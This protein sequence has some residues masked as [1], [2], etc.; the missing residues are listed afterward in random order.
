LTEIHV[1]PQEESQNPVQE[2]AQIKNEREHKSQYHNI[3]NKN[4]KSKEY[5]LSQCT[6]VKHKVIK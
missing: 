1:E 4:K 5:L 3:N 2:S 6:E